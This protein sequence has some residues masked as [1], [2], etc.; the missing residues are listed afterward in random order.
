MVYSDE[1]GC[2]VDGQNWWEWVFSSVKAVLHIM[3][4]DRSVDVIKATMG[5]ATVDVWVSDCYPAQMKAPGQ[6]HQLCL[7][8]PHHPAGWCQLRNLQAVARPLAGL[9]GVDQTPQAFW[10]RAM[11]ALF[12]AGIH[13]HNQRAELSPATFAQEHQRLERLCTWL[14]K[15]PVRE[16]EAQRLLHRYQKYR[17]TLLVFLQR[18]DVSPTNNVSERHLRPSVIHR[19]VTGCFRSEWGA[20]TYAA[21]ASVIGTAALTGQNSFEA[22]QNLC[23]AP[24]LPIAS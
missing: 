13:L 18:T 16:K 7:A 8:H 17:A 14:L 9:A 23:G 20:H 4:F 12:R 24:A 2:R 11:Q 10:P 5:Q 15:R 22:I 1:T 6:L 21:L 3:R 19:K